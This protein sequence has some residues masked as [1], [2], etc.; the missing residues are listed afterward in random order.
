MTVKTEVTFSMAIQFA[1][2]LLWRCSLLHL[3][4]LRPKR[5]NSTKKANLLKKKKSKRKMPRRRLRSMPPSSSLTFIQTRSF[6]FAWLMTIS[7]DRELQSL[8]LR[9]TRSGML[10]TLR[11]VSHS[12]NKLTM[13]L[14]SQLPTAIPC[15]VTLRLRS[16]N[17]LCCAS[18][19]R[20]RLKFSKSIAMV[21]HS[22]CSRVCASTSS[23]V[24]V[25]STIFHL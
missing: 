1:T 19:R 9:I 3:S 15:S 21:K 24:V 25:L 6:S 11:D 2:S 7:L 4:P 12:T 20:T 14:Y 22:R 17:F 16:T 13:F 23:V 8:S 10:A 5:R 18:S